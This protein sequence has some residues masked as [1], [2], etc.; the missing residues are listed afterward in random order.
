MEMNHCMQHTKWIVCGVDKCLWL[1]ALNDISAG[2]AE[3]HCKNSLF[4]VL[5]LTKRPETVSFRR[6]NIFFRRLTS[7]CKSDYSSFALL[8]ITLKSPEC[9]FVFLYFIFFVFFFDLE[10]KRRLWFF[11]HRMNIHVCIVCVLQSHKAHACIVHTL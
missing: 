11:G 7:L 5:S 8:I 2:I 9:F 3:F 4:I 10:Q 1:V 6:A